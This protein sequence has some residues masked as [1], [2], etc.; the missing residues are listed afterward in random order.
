MNNWGLYACEIPPSIWLNTQTNIL[1]IE[2]QQVSQSK[3]ITVEVNLGSTEAISNVQGETTLLSLCEWI[4]VGPTF[5]PATRKPQFVPV[6]CS[7]SSL[8]FVF[9]Y[10][11]GFIY[12][13]IIWIIGI[14]E[15]LYRLKNKCTKNT[16]NGCVKVLYF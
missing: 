8:T 11:P 6:A 16:Q 13:S 1:F 4:R 5:L 3:K 7:W 15:N 9:F 14:K 12:F 2:K 10:G